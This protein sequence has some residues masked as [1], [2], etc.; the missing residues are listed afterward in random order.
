M[1]VFLRVWGA[2]GASRGCMRGCKA[3]PSFFV[4]SLQVAVA[5]SGAK[6]SDSTS[7]EREI[8]IFVFSAVL[9]RTLFTTQCEVGALISDFT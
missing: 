6:V 4:F 5:P 2:P 8:V 1:Y 3:K 7:L 9:A